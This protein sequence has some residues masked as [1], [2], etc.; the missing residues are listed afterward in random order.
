V[1]VVDQPILVGWLDD[2]LYLE[3]NPTQTQSIDIENGVDITPTPLTDKMREMIVEAAGV[4]A[5]RV[6]WGVVEKTIRERRGVPVLIA[7]ASARDSGS[8]NNADSGTH[9]SR[10]RQQYN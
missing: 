5:S 9:T 4:A 7:T 1:T 8:K 2:G 6:N 10:Q 3:A